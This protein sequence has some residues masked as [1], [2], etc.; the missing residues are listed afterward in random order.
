MTKR[1][2]E[3]L[4]HCPTGW[5][6]EGQTIHYIDLQDCRQCKY[7]LRARYTFNHPYP[8]AVECSFDE[9]NAV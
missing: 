1:E 6:P 3:V 7:H 9:T 8:D 4:V 2:V 5:H